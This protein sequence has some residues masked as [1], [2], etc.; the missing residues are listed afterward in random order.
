D[1]NR[2]AANLDVSFL[3][4]NRAKKSMVFDHLASS[5]SQRELQHHDIVKS[6]TNSPTPDFELSGGHNRVAQPRDAGS[7]Y[8]GHGW[9]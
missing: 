9:E 1:D 5:A 6:I 3:F 2:V 4:I 7:P 8:M